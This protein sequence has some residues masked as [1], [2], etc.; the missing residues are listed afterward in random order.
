MNLLPAKK[1]KVVVIGH[2]NPDTD[3]ICSAI[4]YAH[5]KNTLYEGGY[6]PG[7][8]G[9]IN[10]ETRYVLERF[11]MELP[12]LYEDVSA[13]VEDIDIRSVAGAPESATIHSAL[14]RM[15]DEQVSTLPVVSEDQRLLGLVTTN[16]LA[17]SSMDATSE[18]LAN[19]S[20]P[21]EN[22]L[23]TLNG[24]LLTGSLEGSVV[25]GKIVLG[26]GSPELIETQISPGDVV[27]CGN[28]FD[29]QITAIEMNAACIVLCSETAPAKTIVR[30]AEEHD[31]SI[32]QTPLDTFTVACTI[33]QS[34]PISWFMYRNLVTLKLNDPVET[35]REIM[36]K[37]RYVYF[38][39]LDSEG[40]YRG[41]ISRR[42]LLNLRRRQL[43]L[44]DHNERSQCVEGHEGAEIL[45]I[46]D[47]HR[48][49]SIETTGP[50]FFR[51]QPV[52]CTA[53]IIRQL[54][55]ENGVEIPPDI[56]GILC[57]A[58]LSDTLMFRSPTCTPLDEH[59]A[60]E[61]AVLAGVDVEELANEMFEAGE[62]VE[63]RTPESLFYQ[64]FKRFHNEGLDFAVG[65]GSYIS[66]KNLRRAE[67]LLRGYLAEALHRERVSVIYYLLTDIKAQESRVICVGEDAER[68]LCSAFSCEKK[69]GGYLLP[70]VISRKKQ[71]I[72]ALLDAMQ[73][74]EPALYQIGED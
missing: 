8:A 43:I 13:Q 44:V 38:P 42:N 3:S 41:V 64:D 55:Q 12:K 7:R 14:I 54:Y 58:I 9:E 17:V 53:T 32:I 62:N 70:G 57:S 10:Q 29:A 37:V 59:T 36:G 1:R 49:N 18:T 51:N 40:I 71:F 61:L 25:R 21:L 65:Q 33:N 56:A 45:E 39:V 46:I 31:I 35:A 48:I 50:V 24:T 69:D 20:T 73:A 52:G 68:Y 5:L 27:I 15:R 74:Q 11:G 4:A 28:R 16:H 72:P 2:K 26:S 67:K 63:G 22:I 66:R 19:A 23:H 6:K 30:L 60:R 47:H 34:A